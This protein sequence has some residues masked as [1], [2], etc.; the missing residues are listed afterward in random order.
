MA[1]WEPRAED[2]EVAS[3]SAQRP[4]H[5]NRL[6]L[7]PV[8]VEAP[9][10]VEAALQ[11]EVM[12]RPQAAPGLDPVSVDHYPPRLSLREMRHARDEPLAVPPPTTRS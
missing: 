1:S 2:R 11:V 10:Q 5:P 8:Q 12:T 3:A 7:A 4:G 6:A 9:L